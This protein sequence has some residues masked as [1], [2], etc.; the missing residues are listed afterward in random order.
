MAA[1]DF[2]ASAS[3]TIQDRMERIFRSGNQADAEFMRPT[4]SSMALTREQTAN[5][6]ELRDR[7]SN[8]CIGYKVFWQK[9]TTDDPTYSGAISGDSLNCTITGTQLEAD[10][11]TYDANKHV[12]YN[13]SVS[14]NDCGNDIEAADRR[15]KGIMK[16]INNIR[17]GFN[18]AVIAFLDANKQDNQDSGVTGID[19]GNGAWAVN[20]DGKTIE[21]PDADLS[22]EKALAFV[23]AVAQN[24]DIFEYFMVHGRYNWYELFHNAAYTRLNDDERSIFA[25]FATRRHY[26]DIRYLDAALAAD[27]NSFVVNPDSLVFINKIIYPNFQ[28]EML[29]EKDG[30][31]GFSLQDPIWRYNLNGTLIPVTYT[32]VMTKACSARD[33]NGMPYFVEN[34]EVSLK[35]DLATGPEGRNGETGILKLTGVSGV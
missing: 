19:R 16:A 11:K 24:N 14:T 3:L 12:R 2:T 5:V 20:A 25:T 35:Y 21:I 17:V 34:Y 6:Q 15:A 7:I 29:S 18:T 32:V 27:H 9:G 28:A 4:V 22:D 13:V 8:Q 10:S 33:T 1:G 30:M 31:W 26:Y 23:D